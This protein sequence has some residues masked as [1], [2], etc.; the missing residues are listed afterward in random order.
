[1]DQFFV[2]HGNQ[3]LTFFY[4]EPVADNHQTGGI[5]SISFFYYKIFV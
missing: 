5:E 3:Y 4:Q 1:M 2:Q